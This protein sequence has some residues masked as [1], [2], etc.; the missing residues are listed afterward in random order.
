MSGTF[1]AAASDEP[2]M[3]IRMV[4]HKQPR[5]KNRAGRSDSGFGFFDGLSG[6]H[7]SAPD[8]DGKEPKRSPWKRRKPTQPIEWSLE[9]TTADA[10][11]AAM[12]D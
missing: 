7:R 5:L 9:L 11:L 10:S 3:R 6:S 2:S 12:D 8:T 4:S 1:V